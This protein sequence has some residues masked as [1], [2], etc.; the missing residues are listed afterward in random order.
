ML[1]AK[2][3]GINKTDPCPHETY[4]LVHVLDIKQ[5]IMDD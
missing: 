3:T 4:I 5:I 2:G 1:G